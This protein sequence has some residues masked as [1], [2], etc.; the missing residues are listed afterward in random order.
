MAPILTRSFFDA[1]CV[2]VMDS[3]AVLFEVV[4]F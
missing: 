4:A 3:Q 2:G 1:G